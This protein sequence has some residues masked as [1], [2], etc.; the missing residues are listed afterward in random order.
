MG[1]EF[2]KVK[3]LFQIPPKLN[4]YTEK[5]KGAKKQ[6]I[7]E[8]NLAS[9]LFSTKKNKNIQYFHLVSGLF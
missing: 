1:D 8:C 2:L 6:R 3:Y 5:F 9:F 7:L 4:N